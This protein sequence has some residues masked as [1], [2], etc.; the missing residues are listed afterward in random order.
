MYPGSLA[1]PK[2]L[3][4][5]AFS[6]APRFGTTYA[7]MRLWMGAWS[8]TTTASSTSGCF[9]K[10]ASI[11][12]SSTR[13]PRT[14]TCRSSR[15][16]NSKFPSERYRTRSPVLY[17]RD[18][19]PSWNDLWINFSAVNSGWFRYPR[20]SPA[21]PI[22][23]SPGIPSPTGFW[24]RSKTNVCTFAIGRPMGTSAATPHWISRCVKSQTVETTVA[25]VGP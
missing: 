7:I 25:S 8:S 13:K 10:T 22:Y 19:R 18:S 2:D 3:I 12:F 11:P 5:A 20:A 21:P 15:P 17:Q 23:S 1:L 9:L 16:K 6:A 24:F 14:L 4:S